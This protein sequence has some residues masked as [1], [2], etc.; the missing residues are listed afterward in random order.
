MSEKISENIDVPE[1]VSWAESEVAI[2]AETVK[3]NFFI[4]NI[5]FL[6]YWEG[7]GI[8]IAGSDV[9]YVVVF[10]FRIFLGIS[11]LMQDSPYYAL[12]ASHR[13]SPR[14]Y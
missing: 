2:R 12:A 14:E 10:I 9:D 3:I 6:F 8:Y 13:H 7:S 4:R 1:P 11:I 5:R